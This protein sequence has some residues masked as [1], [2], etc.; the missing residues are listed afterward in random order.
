L[1]LQQEI[2]DLKKDI[3]P[4]GMPNQTDLSNLKKDTNADLKV[5]LASMNQRY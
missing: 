4:I 3:T 2:T 1:N 5:D